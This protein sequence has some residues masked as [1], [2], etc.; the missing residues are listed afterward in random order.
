MIV[1]QIFRTLK[2]L[3]DE[4]NT[5][6][7]VE[8]NARR[9]LQLADRGY[10]LERGQIALEGEAES[11]LDNPEVQRT[12]LGRRADEMPTTASDATHAP[13]T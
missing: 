8:Q 5:I 12:Y 2:E 3:K 4:G 10:V 9:A 1:T 6:F 13:G 11:L 7:L